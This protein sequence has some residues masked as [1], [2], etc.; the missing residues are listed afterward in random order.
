M[1]VQAF[2]FVGSAGA[3]TQTVEILEVQSNAISITVTYKNAFGVRVRVNGTVASNIVGSW[4]N[5]L[6]ASSV[7]VPDLPT[8]NKIT[9][10][11]AAFN[12]FGELGPY[13]T[14]EVNGP[15]VS[16]GQK[17]DPKIKSVLTSPGSITVG[18][19]CCG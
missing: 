5:R 13:V 2:G 6:L 10:E 3:N 18:C 7:I 14:R 8:S 16:M 9:L 19:C 15:F 17:V 4:N 12:R 11:I 1:V